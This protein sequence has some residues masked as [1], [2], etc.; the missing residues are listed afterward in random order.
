M[1]ASSA[2]APAAGVSPPLCARELTSPEL[3]EDSV[4]EEMVQAEQ[5][6]QSVIVQERHLEQQ[7]AE[8]ESVI[9]VSRTP[10][11]GGREAGSSPG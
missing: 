4:D 8:T 10:P 2:A 3:D 6:L 7:L 11:S 9:E 5:A 1:P